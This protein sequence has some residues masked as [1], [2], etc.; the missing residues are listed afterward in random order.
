M[1]NAGETLFGLFFGG[2][3][4]SITT[5]ATKREQTSRAGAKVTDMETRIRDLERDAYDAEAE[6]SDEIEAIRNKH[7]RNLDDIEE[8][9]I[10]L[11]KDDITLRRWEIVWVPV[12]ASV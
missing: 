2:R 12:S 3:K 5:A 9:S 11:E 1:V 4:R 7:L 8:R 6:L 10:G